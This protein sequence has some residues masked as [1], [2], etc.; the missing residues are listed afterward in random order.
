MCPENVGSNKDQRLK[1]YSWGTYIVCEPL[2]IADEALK[3]GCST[4]T[5]GALDPRRVFGSGSVCVELIKVD[6]ELVWLFEE[7]AD[8]LGIVGDFAVKV[9]SD[10]FTCGESYREKVRE[11]NESTGLSGHFLRSFSTGATDGSWT[12]T[13]RGSSRRRG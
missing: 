4:L 9:V 8:G 7:I 5:R 6:L 12:M 3:V 10:V 1:R 11:T 2:Q 13:G